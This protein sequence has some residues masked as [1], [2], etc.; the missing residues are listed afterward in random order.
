MLFEYEDFADFSDCAVFRHE[1]LKL[2]V[3]TAVGPRILYFGHEDGPNHLLVREEHRGLVGGE[4][5]SYGGHRLWT[6]PEERPKTYTSDSFPVDVLEEGEAVRFAA[7]VDEFSIQKV[8]RVSF[9]PGGFR[10][11]HQLLNHGGYEVELCPWA[12]TVMAPGGECVAPMHQVRAQSAGLLPVQPVVL[13]GYASMSDPRYTWGRRVARLRSTDDAEPT[14]FGSYISQGLAAYSNRGETFVKRFSVLPQSASHIDMGCNFESYT[15]AG[16]LEVESLGALQRVRSGGS[17][18]V[19][20]EE[21]YLVDGM[22]P[23]EDE[24]AGDWFEALKL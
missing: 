20:T 6:G 12:I 18:A 10:I 11:E 17:T 2:I 24:A 19:H 9:I 1:Q 7:H 3:T 22:V 15:K 14:K 21:W 4:Y 16:M 23:A 5:R 13:W 8:I